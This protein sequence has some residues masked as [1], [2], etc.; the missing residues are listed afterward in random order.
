M[1]DKIR[2]RNRYYIINSINADLING[3]ATFELLNQYDFT[4]MFDDNPIDECIT[5][6]S[7]FIVADS[8]DYTADSNCNTEELICISA[9]STYYTADSTEHKVDLDCA[10]IPVNCETTMFSASDSMASAGIACSSE[11]TVSLWHSGSEEFPQVGDKIFSDAECLTYP[12][13]GFIKV[14]DENS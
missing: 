3:K 5:A 14:I 9:D 8:T 11:F 13:D 4:E 6:D 10:E 1:N 2:F 7:T 12:E